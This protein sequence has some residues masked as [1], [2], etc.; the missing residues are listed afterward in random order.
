ML[1]RIHST[2]GEPVSKLDGATDSISGNVALGEQTQRN[3]KLPKNPLSLMPNCHFFGKMRR[4]HQLIQCGCW[5][6]LQNPHQ[7]PWLNIVFDGLHEDSLNPPCLADRHI[8]DVVSHLLCGHANTDG[9]HRLQLSIKA[10]VRRGC[11][12]TVDPGL[13]KHKGPALRIRYVRQV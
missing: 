13:W 2:L 3:I 4:H 12:V 6:Y 7:L 5:R 1:Q 11:V 10:G 8:D 9:I